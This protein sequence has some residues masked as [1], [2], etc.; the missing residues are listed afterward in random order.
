MGSHDQITVA[1]WYGGA[2]AQL[3]DIKMAD[4][5]KID[6]GVSQL[7]QAMATYSSAHAGFDPTTAM[8]AP[9]DAGLQNA[10]ATA[11]HA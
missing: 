2:G 7:V 10:I 1:G 6:A 8:Q 4:G 11:W 3:Q 5:M 9:T